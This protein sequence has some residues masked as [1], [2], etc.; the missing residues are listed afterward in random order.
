[1][2]LYRPQFPCFFQHPA[3]RNC[4]KSSGLQ[5]SHPRT[6]G[7][8]NRCRCGE[9][10]IPYIC[11]YY[12]SLFL[13]PQVPWSA[14]RSASNVVITSRSSSSLV[15]DVTSRRKIVIIIAN[16]G[17]LF[18]SSPSALALLNDPGTTDKSPQRPQVRVHDS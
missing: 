18:V 14:N 11:K 12:P 9:Q 7:W 4:T 8:L 15:K 2:M 10:S 6:C 13:C 16:F 3:W 5:R 17:H 1:M